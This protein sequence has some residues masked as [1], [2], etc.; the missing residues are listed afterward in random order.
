MQNIQNKKVL[1]VSCYAKGGVV[2]MRNIIIDILRAQGCEV[3]LA[4]PAPYKMH[5][6]LSVRLHKLFS[7]ENVKSESVTGLHGETEVRVGVYGPELEFLKYRTNEI[8]E[9]LISEHDLVCCVSGNVLPLNLIPKEKKVDF[10][11]IATSYWEE[12]KTHFMAQSL[13]V[14]FVRAFD[15]LVCLLMEKKIL[16]ERTITSL[17]DY[18]KKCFQRIT[19]TFKSKVV[20]MPIDSDLQK[21]RLVSNERV[22][23]G[24]CGRTE[25]P[26]K[27]LPLFINSLKELD[28]EGQEFDVLIVGGGVPSGLENEVN[29][30]RQRHN[31]LVQEFC[32][33]DQLKE[34]YKKMDMLVISS[35]QEGLAIV[36]LE[37]M[38][39]GS[40]V[41]ST[42][43]GGPEEYIKDGHNGYLAENDN[44]V[45]LT[46]K[47]SNLIDNKN[48]L[49]NLKQNSFDLIQ[50]SYESGKIKEELAQELGFYESA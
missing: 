21:P 3:T 20:P 19:K 38:A 45:D 6:H 16:G 27:N 35:L 26:R 36:G 22:C 31:I 47:I 50:D 44:V 11:W 37:A 5:P 43:C 41:I 46:K 15:S 9:N 4:Y 33:K 13:P 39:F 49:N 25:D 32:A 34:L 28:R 12:R 18:T 29:E 1:L 24:F 10:S 2:A 23:I 14:K 30:L 8:W 48:L 17:S 7:N 42:K 40:P